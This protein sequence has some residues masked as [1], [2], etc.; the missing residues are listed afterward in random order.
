[1]SIIK[2]HE[3][4]AVIAKRPMLTIEELTGSIMTLKTAGLPEDKQFASDLFEELL[5]SHVVCIARLEIAQEQ[6]AQHILDK[7]TG[8]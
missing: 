6:L 4:R 8:K 7:A 3:K 5:S 1:M 2:H